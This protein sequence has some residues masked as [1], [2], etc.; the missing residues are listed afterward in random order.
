[1]N[2]ASV[3]LI[4]PSTSSFATGLEEPIPTFPFVSIANIVLPIPTFNLPVNNASV[5]LIFPRTSSLAA[6][7]EDPIPTFPFVSIANIVLPIPTFNRPV[8]SASVALISPSTSSLAAGLEEPIPTFPFASI[9]N[10]VLPIPTFNLP[11]N[12]G[13]SIF[14]FKSSAVE[15]SVMIDFHEGGIFVKNVISFK[16]R[17]VIPGVIAF[18]DILQ[19]LKKYCGV[20]TVKLY[21]WLFVQV[22]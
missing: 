18:T 2:N 5:A 19:Y 13:E 8:N 14:A 12:V 4:S 11:V 21:F 6:G 7:L 16:D 10:I 17:K 20:F 15:S 3:A 22:D 9:A 1:M